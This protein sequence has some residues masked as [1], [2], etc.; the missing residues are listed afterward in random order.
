MTNTLNRPAHVAPGES[1]TTYAR[2]I[3]CPSTLPAWD[4]VPLRVVTWTDGTTASV[5]IE[6]GEHCHTL[7]G[8]AIRQLVC[9]LLEA[10]AA[11]AAA[12]DAA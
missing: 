4:H 1:W 12:G 5:L 9:A 11:A 8:D 6:H 10:Q 7:D 3:E 2:D